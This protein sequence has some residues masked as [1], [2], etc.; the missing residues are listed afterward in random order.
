MWRNRRITLGILLMIFSL[1]IMW[2]MNL[3][4]MGFSVETQHQDLLNL[5]SSFSRLNTF[6]EDSQSN[7][8]LDTVEMTYSSYWGGKRHER[9]SSI[10]IDSKGNM[11]LAS[12][13]N[14]ADFPTHNAIKE[15]IVGEQVPYLD[16]YEY[17]DIVVSKF[18][19]D[20][21]SV[22]FSTFI[23]GNA[24]ENVY[25]VLTD[26]NDN[27]VIVGWTESHDFP[28]V[29]AYNETRSNSFGDI[30]VTKLSPD[31]QTILYSTY[32]GG[33][34]YYY[35]GD[36]VLDSMDNIII[37]ASTIDVNFP[38]A[39]AYQA[40]NAS[41]IDAVITKLSA[42]GQSVIFS[43]YFGGNNHEAILSLALDDDENIIFSGQ[44]GSNESFPLV[45]PIV[46]T[47]GDFP[48]STFV[49]KMSADGQSLLFSSYVGD[50]HGWTWANDVATDADNN[51]IMVGETNST[52]FLS[53]NAWQT[54]IYNDSVYIDDP[55]RNYFDFRTHFLDA[56]VVKINSN[57]YSVNFS[58]RIG[59]SE[60]DAAS[61]VAVDQD[62]NI[63]VGGAAF[64]FDFPT[65]AN[66]LSGPR[67]FWDGFVAK[68]SADG[69][70]AQFI[71]ILGGGENDFVDRLIVNNSDD[72]H[73]LISGRAGS[74]DFPT[75]NAIQP[76][77]AF[78]SADFRIQIYDSFFTVL[79]V[80][81]PRTTAKTGIPGFEVFF[82]LLGIG[83][84]KV[85]RKHLKRQK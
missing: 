51:I 29:N 81:R 72:T 28:T 76:N 14:S 50:S 47:F 31:G 54:E 3:Q 24:S 57:D 35:D 2:S 62:Q 59:G 69:Q 23:G 64:S 16:E 73:I 60:Y 41:L 56:I 17:D 32:L 26:S 80:Q 43:T 33:L 68:F 37:G 71:T 58:T 22:I 34:S 49:G 45:N 84:L 70:T 75:V 82:A 18:S 5:D 25:N 53:V 77:Y 4:V 20:G 44:T 7:D 19:P 85:S 48:V 13:S 74:L 15:S 8:G 55:R 63:I 9:V 12:A 30:F 67:I 36:F 6:N 38:I 61:T 46:S 52:K 1:G 65:T 83:F 11:I 78:F 27:I 42:D 79:T 40:T 66:A 10:A 21:K 39:N